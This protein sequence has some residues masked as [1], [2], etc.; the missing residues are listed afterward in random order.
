MTRFTITRLREEIA[1]MNESL[2]E[3]NA[4]VRFVEQGRNGYQ[5][6]D[7]HEVNGD[8]SLASCSRNVGCGSSREVAGYCWAR[9][10]QIY[11][12]VQE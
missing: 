10:Y 4:P 8:G 9:Y 2:A 6:V 11:A 12:K 1:E 7:E 3:I 5:A